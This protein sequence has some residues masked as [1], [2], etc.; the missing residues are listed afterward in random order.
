MDSMN[1]SFYKFLLFHLDL[2][3]KH[4]QEMLCLTWIHCLY[5]LFDIFCG[6]VLQP[7]IVLEAPGPMG[8]LQTIFE[9]VVEA[10]ILAK[11]LNDSL[12]LLELGLFGLLE[13]LLILY[14]GRRLDYK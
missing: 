11:G 10:F 7:R 12:F 8:H 5:F 13:L 14:Y 9:E 2:S 4:L 6:Q 1:E 3:L